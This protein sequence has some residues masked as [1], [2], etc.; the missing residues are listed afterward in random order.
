[1]TIES[2]ELEKAVLLKLAGRMDA[3]HAEQFRLECEDWISRGANHLL[4]DFSALQYLNSVGLNVI[5][6]IGKRMQ[7]RSGSVVL[8][9]L[10]G[11]SRRLFEVTRLIGLFPVF[12]TTEAAGASLS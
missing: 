11:L 9:S 12:D 8:C 1:M 10:A 7:V 6:E 2:T 4:L 5:L 3:A